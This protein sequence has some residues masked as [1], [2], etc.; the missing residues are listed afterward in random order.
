MFSD[1]IIWCDQL[2][3]DGSSM[4]SGTLLS[5]SRQEESQ[6]RSQYS[7]QILNP[8]ICISVSR[9]VG[10]FQKRK[11][12]KKNKLCISSDMLEGKSEKTKIAWPKREKPKTPQLGLQKN[13]PRGKKKRYALPARAVTRTTQ[14][15]KSG[16]SDIR[17]SR[18]LAY[19]SRF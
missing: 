1:S 10:I 7:C 15:R 6:S 14:P 5:S 17:H 13:M 9:G 19:L 8:S 4:P 2:I 12:V 18:F 11:I 16:Y 3:F